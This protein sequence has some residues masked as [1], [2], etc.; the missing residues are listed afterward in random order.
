MK[1][2]LIIATIA[3]LITAG[4]VSFVNAQSNREKMNKP[5]LTTE[6]KAEIEVRKAEMQV[7]HEEMQNIMENGTYEEWKTLVESRPRMTDYITEKNFTKFQEAHKLKQA[8]DYEG[9]QKIMTELGIDG[10]IGIMGMGI[11][12]FFHKRM[13]KGMNDECPFQK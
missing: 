1:K 3:F 2:T 10:K 4:I 7:K 5:E 9:A 12:K 11:N 6:M 8:G 13:N